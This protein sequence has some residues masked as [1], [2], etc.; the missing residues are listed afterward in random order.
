M[1]ED[2]IPIGKGRDITH[3]PG[4]WHS[5]QKRIISGIEGILKLGYDDQKER[6]KVNIAP[7][8]SDEL[9]DFIRSQ[10]LYTVRMAIGGIITHVEE[11]SRRSPKSV[12]FSTNFCRSNLLATSYSRYYC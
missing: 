3:L 9:L 7:P 6:P 4:L 1:L 8:C 2:W 5:L 12:R 11:D 10:V